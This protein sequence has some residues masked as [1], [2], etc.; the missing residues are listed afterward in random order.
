[1][2]N[3][4]HLIFPVWAN[5]SRKLNDVYNVNTNLGCWS[6]YHSVKFLIQK[7]WKLKFS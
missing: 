2:K 6:Q 3:V 7:F 4:K 1:M 5:I